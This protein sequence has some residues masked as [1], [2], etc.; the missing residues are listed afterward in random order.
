MKETMF[1]PCFHHVFTMFSPFSLCFHMHTYVFTMLSPSLCCFHLVFTTLSPRFHM[2]LPRFRLFSPCLLKVIHVLTT[3][4]SVFN[5]FSTVSF[6]F[7]CTWVLSIS[8]ATL[9]YLFFCVFVEPSKVSGE[10]LRL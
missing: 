1:S 5:P 8:V 3:F 2:F 6:C 10:K 4:S 7:L 9:L